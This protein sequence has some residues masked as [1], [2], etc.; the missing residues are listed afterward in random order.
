M[1]T[2]L[3]YLLDEDFITRLIVLCAWVSP[4]VGLVA[5]SIYGWTR[6]QL[7][8]GFLRGLGL[9]CLGTLVW[10]MWT[11]YSALTDHYGLDSV[12][13]LVINLI[14]FLLTGIVA[15]LLYRWLF[16]K[17]AGSPGAIDVSPGKESRSDRDRSDV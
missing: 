8:N 12:K 13:N 6:G 14:I 15:G 17:T 3:K 1:E 9:G 5:G 4:T 11:V 2:I 16:L 10:V 7:L